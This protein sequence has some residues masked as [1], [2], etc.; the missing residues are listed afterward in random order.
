MEGWIFIWNIKTRRPVLK[1]KAHES[2][3]M[4]VKVTDNDTLIRL[5]FIYKWIVVRN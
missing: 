2:S 5:L 3:C 4:F 1:W